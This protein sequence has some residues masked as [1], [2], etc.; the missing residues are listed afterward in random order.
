MTCNRLL[1]ATE[2]CFRME[3]CMRDSTSNSHLNDTVKIF[4]MTRFRQGCWHS[5]PTI[6]HIDRLSHLDYGRPTWNCMKFQTQVHVQRHSKLANSLTLFQN[7]YW[8]SCDQTFWQQLSFWSIIVVLVL[9]CPYLPTP[10]KF[11]LFVIHY[12]T[13]S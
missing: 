13:T 11:L 3:S 4:F 8:H 1:I 5:V 6:T 9:W 2:K 12:L 7:E 10:L